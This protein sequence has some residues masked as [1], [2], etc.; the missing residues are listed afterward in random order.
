MMTL[1]SVD[2]AFSSATQDAAK[3][4]TCAINFQIYLASGT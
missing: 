1:R 4:C 3:P 2:S